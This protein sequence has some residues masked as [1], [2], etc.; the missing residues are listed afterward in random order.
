MQRK[1][2][3][4]SAYAIHLSL[5]L[6]LLFLKEPTASLIASVLLLLDMGSL[7]ILVA[8]ERWHAT[9]SLALALIIVTAPFVILWFATPRTSISYLYG[10]IL[11][12][13][14]FIL[15]IVELILGWRGYQFPNVQRRRRD[16]ARPRFH[17][18]P[19]HA[20]EASAIEPITATSEERYLTTGG[21]SVYHRVG[22]RSLDE[23]NGDE[24]I[25]LSSKTEAESLGLEPCELCKP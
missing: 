9:C 17:L 15:F 2:W 11:V 1:V 21:T 22:C 16:G 24:L 23:T 25:H 10:S 14:S 6:V 8:N 18:A 19:E 12:L 4:L 5:V 3:A 7:L 20:Q 13:A